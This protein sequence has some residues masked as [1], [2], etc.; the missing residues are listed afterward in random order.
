M[1]V[2]TGAGFQ[3]WSDTL[4][5]EPGG[6]E[7]GHYHAYVRDFLGEI[8]PSLRPSVAE[9][10]S[11]SVCSDSGGPQRWLDFN[12]G[13]VS[14]IPVEHLAGQYGGSSECA[15]MLLFCSFFHV[16]VCLSFVECACYSLPWLLMSAAD[17]IFV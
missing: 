4:F 13:R 11:A 8:N 15:C 2:T 7:G 16:V 12:D 6:A 14:Y 1:K 9:Y 17:V 5:C 10:F 3:L